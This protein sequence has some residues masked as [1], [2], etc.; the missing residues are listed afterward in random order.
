MRGIDMN[1][2]VTYLNSSLRYFHENERHINRFCREYVLLLVFEGVLRFS[3]DGTEYEIVPGQY[4]IQKINSYQ[5]GTRVSLSPRYLYV[6]FFAE[7]A[8]GGEVVPFDGEYDYG[9]MES[10]IYRLDSL[11]HNGGTFI[12]KTAVFYKILSE[13]YQSKDRNRLSDRIA[14]FISGEIHSELSLE[15][16]CREFHYSKNHIINVLKA[17]RGMTPVEFMNGLRLREAESL[18]EITSDPIIRISETCGF[19][20]YS[21]FFRLFKRKN[22]VSPAEWRERKRYAAL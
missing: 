21:H 11:S 6:H 22:G 1:K 19:N 5:S 3:E 17:E 9:E 13:L 8:D 18:L 14:A 16:L 15:T 2:P 12:E 7:S 10:L 4:H 20:N